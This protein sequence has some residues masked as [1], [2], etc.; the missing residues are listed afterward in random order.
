MNIT[1]IKIRKVYSESRLRALVSVTFD[2]VFAVH[3]IKVIDGP[4]RL[5]VA[6]P[7]R[8]DEQ[9]VFRDICHPITSLA[10]EELERSI[11]YAYQQHMQENPVKFEE[12]EDHRPEVL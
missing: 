8:R 12:K 1:D 4:Q 3:D 6:M 9:G 5:F 2:N 11:V 10:R 7:S